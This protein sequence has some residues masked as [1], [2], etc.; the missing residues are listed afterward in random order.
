[1][2][3][4]DD[5]GKLQ[6]RIATLEEE[7]AEF[8]RQL[9]E[10]EEEHQKLERVRRQWTA[11]LDAVKDPVFVHDEAFR[12]IRANEAYARQAGL[13]VKK[14][15]GKPYWQVFPKQ[16]EPL[17]GCH[18]ATLAQKGD[19]N[20]E[21]SLPSGQ[22]FHS[23]SFCQQEDGAFQCIH[24]LEDITDR[25]KLQEALE[26]EHM[27][28][29]Q[30]LE[31]AG[32]MLILL[33]RRGNVQMINRMGCE[34]L[35]LAEKDI[36]GKNWF[37]HFLPEQAR[38]GAKAVFDRLMSGDIKPVEFFENPV[39]SSDGQEHLIA[40]HN[41]LIRD[42]HGEPAF[43][44]SSGNDITEFRRTQQA[45]QASE[46]QFHLLFNTIAD[47]IF[48]HDTTGRILRTNLTARDRLGYSKEELLEM[49]VTDI[50][51]AEFAALLPDRIK[52]LLAHGQAVF[53][54]AHV[55]RNGKIIPVEISARVI[56]YHGTSAIISVVRDISESKRSKQLLENS[57]RALR[58]LSAVNEAVVRADDE[59]RLLNKICQTIVD[60]G[61]YRLA[62]IGYA[63][64][65]ENKT[66]RP[67]AHAGHEA[68]YLHGIHISWSDNESG[69]GP[70]G[71]AI[72]TGKPCVIH[73]I[74]H[75]P[76]FALWRQRACKRGYTSSIALPLKSNGEV[77]GALNIYAGSQTTFG[78]DEMHLLEEMAGDIAYGITALR[79]SIAHGRQQKALEEQ[80]IALKMSLTGTVSAAARLIEARDPYTAGHQTRVAK[81][82]VAIARE[83]GWEK[84]RIEGLQL[85]AMIHDIGKIKIPA[86]ILTKPG[87]LT[88][89]EF[90]LIKSHPGT[91]YE[92]L[93]DIA[94]PWPVAGIV[95]QHHERIDG[96]GYPQG[97]MGD[98][99]IE[100]AKIVGV[101]DVVEAMAS[102][103]PYRASLGVEAALA[104][105]EAGRGIRYDEEI[106]NACLR[107]IKEKG[108]DPLA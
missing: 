107:L 96:S 25:V 23:R 81:L 95:H 108:L 43:V 84:E 37:D 68:G 48:I 64:K 49:R 72:R 71:T 7:S 106:A 76:K 1:M 24:I 40:W 66:V 79:T 14:V 56:Q 21:L 50:D 101:A 92:I 105:I 59:Y 104:E 97:L 4:P 58:I 45:A 3:Q 102:H 57:N 73:D 13:P 31:V 38:E 80:Q 20:E 86:D 74:L 69:L 34:I 100:E 78:A 52:T 90:E 85:G 65:D 11:T 93:K 44:L 29:Q 9:D 36:L 60:E 94:F 10:L 55:C 18:K 83:L 89:I 6:E 53:E 70:I 16:K 82:A 42:R 27:Q 91:G 12:I 5:I 46:E 54:S 15:I 33:G 98:Q 87:R 67:V 51:T 2:N 77:F 26:R 88:A 103:R 35:G 63:E 28:T 62:W 39:I 61:G 30:Y 8:H 99:I 19:T 47:A 32:V 22:H 75:D 17:P 41:V